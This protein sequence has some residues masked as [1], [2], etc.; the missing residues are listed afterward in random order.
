[1]ATTIKNLIDICRFQ[2]QDMQDQPYRY[3][4]D[5]LV[6]G[7]DVAFDECYRIRPDIFIRE[8]EPDVIGKPL[9]TEV[10]VPRGYVMAFA[11][12]M[13]GFVSMSDQEDTQD[14]RATVFLNKFVAQLTTTAS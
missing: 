8:P 3:A 6:M 1:M 11:F 2:L 4:D 7:L 9:T 13:C 14:S 5:K 12:Y 10:P